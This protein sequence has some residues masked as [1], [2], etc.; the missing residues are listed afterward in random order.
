MKR[1]ALCGQPTDKKNR[2][3]VSCG[4]WF[5]RK[6]KHFHIDCFIADKRSG[7]NKVREMTHLKYDGGASDG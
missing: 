5:R 3:T 7:Y 2:V 6:R 4:R 1:C